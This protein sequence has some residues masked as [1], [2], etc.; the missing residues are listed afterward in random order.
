[1]LSSAPV[2]QLAD[3]ALPYTIHCD[4]SG[5]ATGAC[6]MQD[7]GEGLQLKLVSYISAKMI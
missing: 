4:A 7:H 3:P 6:L 5:Y 1:M 2:L